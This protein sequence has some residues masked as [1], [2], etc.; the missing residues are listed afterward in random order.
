[1]SAS[2]T[3]TNSAAFIMR[4]GGGN[5]VNSAIPQGDQKNFTHTVGGVT[6]TLEKRI[7][8]HYTEK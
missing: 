4:W 6:K 1:M 7:N 5:H 3:E 8:F 2:N